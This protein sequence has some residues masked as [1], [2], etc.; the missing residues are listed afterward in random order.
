MA[1]KENLLG[2]K[3]GRLTVIAESEKRGKHPY[4][5]TRCDC[6]KE[7]EISATHLKSGKIR[8]CGC[9]QKET[10]LENGKNRKL[11]IFTNQKFGYLTVVERARNRDS[12]AYYLCVCNC[13]NEIE[14]RASVLKKQISCGCI[15]SKMNEK[16]AKWLTAN[17]I[18]FEREYPM[19]G[20]RLKFDFFLPDYNTII[21][22]QGKQH[23]SKVNFKG[24][25]DEQARE[26][27]LTQKERDKLK[28]IY[29]KYNGIKLIELPFWYDLEEFMG[30]ILK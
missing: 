6:G 14:I 5:L 23:Y 4:W 22:C 7:K 17:N 21:E 18:P 24:I 28:R 9:L 2:R 30:G 16:V 13:G 26:R 19:P 12:H 29:C 15:L 25:S 11:D 27:L 10:R 8:S 20:F 3:F 1:N